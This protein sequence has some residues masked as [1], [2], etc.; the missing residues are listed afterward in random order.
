MKKFFYRL[1]TKFTLALKTL[2]VDGGF[3]EV[4][5][6][7]PDTPKMKLRQLPHEEIMKYDKNGDGV[8]DEKDV[9]ALVNDILQGNYDLELDLNEDG[10]TDISD[11]VGFVNIILETEKERAFSFELLGY[12]FTHQPE[13]CIYYTT[14]NKKPC[15]IFIIENFGAIDLVENQYYEGLDFGKLVFSGPITRIP[16]YAFYF[17]TELTSISIPRKVINI[18]AHAFANCTRLDAIVLGEDV[19]RINIAV[20]TSEGGSFAFDDCINL[21]H[22]ISLAQKAPAIDWS[23]FRDMG[24]PGERT[25]YVRKESTGYQENWLK[26]GTGMA[27]YLGNYNFNLVY[28]GE[29]NFT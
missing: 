13:N 4:Y 8:V 17:C 14:Y 20:N 2:F 12:D 15:D 19:E 7:T 11:V 16:D 18:G 6:A 5:H 28:L 25:L 22:I 10:E 9:T 27:V 24:K 23:T 26:V 21:G 29:T 1:W 3:V